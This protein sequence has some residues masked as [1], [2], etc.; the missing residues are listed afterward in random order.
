MSSDNLEKAQAEGKYIRKVRSF[1][2]REGRLTKGQ[3]AALER[4][5]PTMGLTHSQGLLNLTEVFGREAPTV[6]E[7]GFGMGRSLVAMAKAAP[8]KNFI[9]IEVHR[10]GVG[11]CLLEAEEAEVSNLR[12][13]EHDAVEVLA[14]CIADGSL[15]TVQVFFPDPWHKKRHHKRRLIQPEFVDLL[16]KKLAIGGVLHLATD[17]QNYAE[18][19][20][21]VMQAAPKWRNLAA[22]NTYVPRPEERP[23]TKFEQRGERLGH[24]VWDLK[25]ERIA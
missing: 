12:V 20:L 8:E 17:W 10:P 24:G 5:W 6:L 7:I 13:Y 9:G 2:K 15:A 11:A 3:A 16:R 23:L 21:E 25:F 1:V 19:M 4:S 22:D 14:D 18:H